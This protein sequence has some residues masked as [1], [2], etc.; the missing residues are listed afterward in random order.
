MAQSRKIILLHPFVPLCLCHFVPANLFPVPLP[1]I[2]GD[3]GGESRV[4]RFDAA[5]HGNGEG[6]Q[7]VEFRRKP[8]PLKAGQKAEALR[9]PELAYVLSLGGK[10]DDRRRRPTQILNGRPLE[11]R[12][13]E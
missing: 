2:E 12:D 11:H 6:P 13:A 10:S 8:G 1:F 5:L 3:A 4:E 7:M 9:K